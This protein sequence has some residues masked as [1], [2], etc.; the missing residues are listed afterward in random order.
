MTISVR[1]A[2]PV[3][4]LFGHMPYRADIGKGKEVDN[5]PQ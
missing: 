4:T 5:R 2:L 3:V 1:Q